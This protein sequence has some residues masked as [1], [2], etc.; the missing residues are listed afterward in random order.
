M[1][2]DGKA[3][4][5]PTMIDANEV[6]ETSTFFLANNKCWASFPRMSKKHL[7]NKNVPNFC[8]YK[9]SHGQLLFFLKKIY[10]L[11]WNKRKNK[12]RMRQTSVDDQW[13]HS[14]KSPSEKTFFFHLL[15]LYPFHLRIDFQQRG[16][17]YVCMKSYA[18]SNKFFRNLFLPDQQQQI[19]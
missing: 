15:L 3:Y 7:T 16:S 18:R 2:G 9:Y 19:D 5:T 17:R 8:V 6:N 14:S 4:L 1:L 11:A 10:F 12:S 13:S